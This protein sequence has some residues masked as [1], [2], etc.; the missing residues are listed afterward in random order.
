M[1]G[2]CEFEQFDRRA[3]LDD[4]RDADTVGWAVRRNQ[5]FPARKLG[6][7]VGH[8]KRDVRHSPDEI[9]NRPVHFE[10][11]PFHT[12]FAFLVTDN[13]EFQMLQVG[14]ARLR[15]GS[16]CGDTGALFFLRENWRKILFYSLPRLNRAEPS[17]NTIGP[18]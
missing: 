4:E 12:E 3:I 6:G 10:A 11:H 13:K 9:G 15:F 8:F 2:V 16:R 18:G 17:E 7:E 1:F 5:D 14:L